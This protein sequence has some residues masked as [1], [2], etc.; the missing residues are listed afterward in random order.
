MLGSPTETRNAINS[1]PS[2]IANDVETTGDDGAEEPK[3]LSRKLVGLVKDTTKSGV[4][5]VLF[6]DRLKASLGSRTAKRRLGTLRDP[7]AETLLGPV[8]FTA[9]YEGQK[10]HVNI[11][12][13]S[14][15]P[16]LTFHPSPVGEGASFS[17]GSVSAPTTGPHRMDLLNK[18]DPRIDTSGDAATESA[19]LCVPISDIAELKKVGGLGWKAKLIVGWGSDKEVADALEIVY[20][21]GI[22]VLLTALPLR[23][24]LFNRLVS[25]GAQEW[26]S[27]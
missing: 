24:E 21:D 4:E 22:S 7:K 10:G 27:R 6:P 11:S 14:K 2:G 23:D 25:I 19:L 8:D 3:G 26:E 13:K 9:R 12:I 20:N 16:C 17:L 15:V 5:T 18:L 1:E